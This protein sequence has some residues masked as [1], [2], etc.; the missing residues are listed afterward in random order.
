[1]RI[2]RRP[3]IPR[4]GALS[5]AICLALSL[6]ATPQ[7]RAVSLKET[8]DWSVDLGG[9]LKLYGLAMHLNWPWLAI[10]V[11]GWDGRSVVSGLGEA[12]L[13]FSGSYKDRVS[14][15]AQIHSAVMTSSQPNAMTAL[16]GGLSALADTPRALPMQYL[17][18]DD[19]STIWKAQ[20]D[21]LFVKLRLWKLDIRIGRQPIGLGVGLI[22]QPADLIGTFSFL[23]I[24]R[25]YKPGVDAVRVDWALGRFTELTLVGVGAGAPCRH[26][27]FPTSSDLFAPSR[28]QT[29]EGEACSPAEARLDANH[30]S[31]LF[32]LRTSLGKFD[33]GLLG[34]YVRGDI[35]AGAFVSA[36]FDRWKIRSEATF[37]HDLTKDIDSPYWT[38]VNDFVRAVVGFDYGFNTSRP[39]DLI[40][41]L[42]YNGF[43]TMDPKGY[44]R[45]ATLARMAEYGEVQNVGLF[46]A[47]M[48][49]RWQAADT[50]DT[51]V[52]IV[53]NLLD[54]SAHLSATVSFSLSDES[55]LLLGGFV[56]MGKGPRLEGAVWA[57]ELV[58]KSEFGL[59]PLMVFSEYKRYF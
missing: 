46:Y 16:S 22:W 15:E 33:L 57:P 40:V 10:A 3:G 37:T 19:P 34:G 20:V 1:M 51:N 17:D 4:L 50:V 43:G 39:L 52:M 2:P 6:V 13:K 23:E 31:G 9:S 48:A 49:L 21:R 55:V 7:A 12:R 53:S 27:T 26:V 59:Y 58:A 30:S 8:D 5:L 32:R 18:T 11:S 38:P 56:P 28:W 35:L 47:G 44:L 25:E 14:W 54:P 42:Y 41:E 36:T 29:P 24:D 45:R